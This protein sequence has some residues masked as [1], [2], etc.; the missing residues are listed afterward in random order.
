MERHN[1]SLQ[2]SRQRFNALINYDK[3]SLNLRKR[4]AI[5]QKLGLD[6]KQEKVERMKLNR[7][8][9]DNLK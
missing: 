4:D 9:F 2:R 7:M 3:D 5:I 6:E 1:D 8:V